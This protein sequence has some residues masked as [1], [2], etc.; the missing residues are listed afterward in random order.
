MPPA[1]SQSKN[2]CLAALRTSLVVALIVAAL[3]GPTHAGPFQDATAAYNRG[4]YA[5]ALRI[6]LDL[7]EKGDAAAQVV[8]GL[9]Y[10]R[11]HGVPHDDALAVQW[12]RRATE[13]GFAW[14]QTN[15][16]YMYESGRGVAKDE[17]EAA[18]WYLK[19]AEQG[20][21]MAQDNLGLLY[22]DGRGVEKNDAA[23]AAWLGKAA[24][25]GYV[26]GRRN[27][28]FD[29]ES[30]RVVA[31]AAE[32]APLDQKVGDQGKAPARSEPGPIAMQANS[33][34]GTSSCKLVQ[35]DQWLIRFSRNRWLVIEGAINGHKVGIL[36]DTG[37]TR[38]MIFR[39]VA[40]RLGLM[41]RPLRNSYVSGFGGISFIEST[42]VGEFRIGES[43]RRNWH[44]MVAGEHD[45]G[46]GIG[47]VL[48]ED[49]FQ[50]VDVEF[51]LANR[52]VRL[53]Q[54]RNCNGTSLAYWTTGPAQQVEMEWLDPER[55]RIIVPVR[56]NGHPIE[57]LFDT[58]AANSM[59]NKIA[60]ARLG[61]RPDTPGVVSGG[62]FV[63]VGEKSSNVWVGPF[64]S[65]E[66]GNEAIKTTT[67]PFG[68]TPTDIQM[69]LGMDFLLAHRL[70]V[71]HS[72]RKIYFT[73]SGGPVFQRSGAAQRSK[74]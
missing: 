17:A 42:Q 23:A 7:A 12:Y 10:A 37:A 48:G 2:K 59:L 43:T 55:P 74:D 14:G 66:I 35:I 33:A 47:V 34:S 20:F 13:Q 5:T 32:A 30:G 65:F 67:I 36:L 57:A 25:Q 51:D 46:D 31:D 26:K 38:T 56:V 52:A 4:D 29:Y 21:P 6:R 62:T 9:M 28:R 50:N 63:G 11:G 27:F 24:E 15:L 1:G 8:L 69:V 60:A 3:P 39:P 22:R 72:Q 68:D 61:V 53:F 44:M 19:A 58:G 70:L 73:Y 18:K 49:F 16:G 54:P 64:E 71:S 40:E 45:P 41:M